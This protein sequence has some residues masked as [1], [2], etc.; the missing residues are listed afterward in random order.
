MVINK[1]NY[2]QLIF[3][4]IFFLY[5]YTSIHGLISCFF[6]LLYIS[7]YFD[8]IFYV[9]IFVI[10]LFIKLCNKCIKCS[11][12]FWQKLIYNFILILLRIYLRFLI[13]LIYWSIKIHMFH[14]NV[15]SYIHKVKLLMGKQKNVIYIYILKLH[16]NLCLESFLKFI[17][18]FS[19]SIQV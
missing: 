3:L 18:Y 15:S 11:Y 2:I 10:I 9:Q 13:F 4:Y 14:T 8:I 16:Q 7:L 1:P 6:I 5:I 12:I 17:N 19:F